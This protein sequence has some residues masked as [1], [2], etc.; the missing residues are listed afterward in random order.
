[1]DG[2]LTWGSIQVHGKKSYI[3]RL[4]SLLQKY[5]YCKD[6]P[7]PGH[8]IHNIRLLI[9][10]FQGF[11]GMSEVRVS[12]NRPP[13]TVFKQS[14]LTT[15]L[16]YNDNQT[17]TKTWSQHV[18]CDE[19]KSMKFWNKLQL[20]AVWKAGNSCYRMLSKWLAIKSS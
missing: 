20:M 17:L 6:Q 2:S 18:S 8:P 13:R 3:S 9:V 16:S 15:T 10:I 19:F 12:L 1:M 7:N 4:Q 14:L 5:L 11:S